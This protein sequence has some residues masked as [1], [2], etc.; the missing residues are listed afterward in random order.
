MQTSRI[1]DFANKSREG[2][3]RWFSEMSLRGLLF[4][5]E[6]RPGDIISNATGEPLFMPDECTKLD[7]I[8]AQMF[9]RFGDDVCEV[10]YPVFMRAAGLPRTH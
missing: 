7:T 6:D 3:L 1:P 2:I 9:D 8:M 10:A 5:P 4:H